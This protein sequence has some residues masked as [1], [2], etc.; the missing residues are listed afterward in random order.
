MPIEAKTLPAWPGEKVL[1]FQTSMTM[2]EG[3]TVELWFLHELR[4]TG[5]VL[6]YS[7]VGAPVRGVFRAQRRPLFELL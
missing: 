5:R 1:L 6:Y 7:K 3:D 4:H 2:R